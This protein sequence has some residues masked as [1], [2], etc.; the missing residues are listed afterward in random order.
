MRVPRTPSGE[1]LSWYLD[2]I[3][4]NMERLT[5]EEVNLHFVRPTDST[6]EALRADWR[7]WS[8]RVGRCQISAVDDSEPFKIVVSIETDKKTHYRLELTTDVEAPHKIVNFE[9]QRRYDFDVLVRE[10]LPEDGPALAEIERRAPIKMGDRLMTFDR[11]ADY[12]AAARLM[13]DA[14]IVVAEVDGIPGAVEWA[15]W[16]RARIGGREYRLVNYIHL[17]VAAEHQRK[18]LWSA[19][20]RKLNEAYPPETKMD[21]GYACAARVN[22]SIQ[23]AFEGRARWSVGP[24]RALLSAKRQAGPLVGR[25]ATKGDAEKIAELLNQTH[26]QEEMYFPCTSDSVRAR[27][28]RAPDLYSWDQVW[29][30]DCAVLGVW[31]AGNQTK[32]V[33]EKDGRVTEAR[34]GL[35]LDYGFLRGAESEFEH[36]LTAWCG[37]LSEHGHTHL[38][39]FTSRPSCSFP[40][41]QRMA[42]HLEQFD[43]WTPPIAEPEG[44]AKHGVFVDQIF[45]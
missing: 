39:I 34:H 16:H 29:L 21:C 28:E 12:F 31:P 10:A 9:W 5:V 22:E 2:T 3:S 4:S 7:G 26:G 41:I 33:T 35:V 23:K 37:W 24:V 1:Q 8:R 43:I 15:A 27:L 40:I 20:V 36:L 11:S 32:V 6:D 13:E 25:V 14:T 30:T 44:A 18:G 45:F 42:D 19:L 38:S 17:R